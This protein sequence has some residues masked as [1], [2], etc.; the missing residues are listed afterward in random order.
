MTKQV[1][2]LLVDDEPSV[3]AALELALEDEPWRI[4]SVSSAEEALGLLATRRFDLLLTDKNLPGMTGVDLIRKVRQDN[5]DMACVMITGYA[6]VESAAE[7]MKLGVDAYVE[8]PFDSIYEVVRRL[9]EEAPALDV[10][11]ARGDPMLAH[12]GICDIG[13]ALRARPRGGRRRLGPH[14]DS[15]Q[16]GVAQ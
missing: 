1:L 16:P 6:S 11:L 8:K 9:R 7:T 12:R 4:E 14:A 10:L 13:R 15:D 3:R 5:L 2:L